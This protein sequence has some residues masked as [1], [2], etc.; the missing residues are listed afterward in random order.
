MFIK[1]LLGID[2]DSE[3]SMASTLKI[4]RARHADGMTV[5]ELCAT[6]VAGE[7][8]VGFRP[9]QN[10]NKTALRAVAGNRAA[11]REPG[12]PKRPVRR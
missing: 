5:K 1:L 2:E 4:R 10:H 12:A 9:R 3:W 8:G 11:E 6:A 7:S